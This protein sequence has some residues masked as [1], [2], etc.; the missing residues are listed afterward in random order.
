MLRRGGGFAVRHAAPIFERVGDSGGVV[1]E[2]VAAR[3]WQEGNGP[4]PRVWTWP[5]TDR[6]ALWVWSGGAWRWAPVTARQDWADGRTAYQVEVDLT[7]STAV[8]RV[9][10]WW[11]HEGLR[12]ARR[13]S[14]GPSRGPGGGGDMPAP[15]RRGAAPRRDVARGR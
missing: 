8:T 11:P 12:V 9:S 7:G 15:L 5:S 6:P 1:R 13:S 3:P 2:P 14:V 4:R 10:Y